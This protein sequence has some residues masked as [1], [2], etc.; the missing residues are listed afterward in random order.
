MPM[1]APPASERVHIGFFGRTNAGKSSIINAVTNQN[2][3]IVSE[4]KG[5]TTDPVTKTMEILP[6]GP[7]VVI[8]T[9]GID[10]DTALGRKRVE[11]SLEVLERCDI[12]VIVTDAAEKFSDAEKALIKKIKALKIPYIVCINKIDA[13][14]GAAAEGDISVSAKT[15]ENIN[16]LKEL[17]AKKINKD[18]NK[19][20][21]GDRL[22][23]GSFV[24]LVI[25]IDSAAP[26]N[27][28]ILPQQMVLREVLDANAAAI[29]VQP[30]ELQGVFDK[31]TPDIVITDSQAF[32]EVSKIVPENIDLTSFSVLM[33][34]YKGELEAAYAGAAALDK[35][36]DGD[37]IL[38]CEGCTH[39]RQCE[40]IG[41]VKMPSWIKKYSGK[42]IEFDFTSGGDFQKSLSGYKLIVHCGGCMLNEKEIRRRMR[43]AEKEG[44]P[45]TNYGIA[46][47]KMNGILERAA[48]AANKSFI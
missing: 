44:V 4:I 14:E 41:S 30:S 19:K 26:K 5:T 45:I 36:S 42:N 23:A 3:S 27:R 35:L 1:S 34:R 47:A 6:M 2:L 29:C 37:K 21:I 9:P 15:G 7:V 25:P 22:R 32:A 38:I 28:I 33:M 17:I 46:I 8:D 40:D 11:K 18:S 13:A 16:A 12:A 10:D 43:L 31:V 48:S 24:V 20:I 39:H